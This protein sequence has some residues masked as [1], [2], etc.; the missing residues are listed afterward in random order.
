MRCLEHVAKA[1]KRYITSLTL[2]YTWFLL[3]LL[4]L[5][6]THRVHWRCTASAPQLG[7]RGSALRTPTVVCMSGSLPSLFIWNQGSENGRIQEVNFLD[8]FETAFLS[9]IISWELPFAAAFVPTAT[10]FCMDG[11]WL[12]FFIWI[13]GSKNGGTQKVDFWVGIYQLFCSSSCCGSFLS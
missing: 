10:M 7:S 12:S 13:Q 1:M 9:L 3:M 2:S 11:F 5:S 6:G 4:F 8:G